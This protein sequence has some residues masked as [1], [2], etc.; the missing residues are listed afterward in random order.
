MATSS[1]GQRQETFSADQA[2]SLCVLS[3]GDQVQHVSTCRKVSL[4][5]G[6]VMTV[7]SVL[8]YG[9]ERQPTRL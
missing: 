7:P 4:G 9:V 6:T 8:V 1:S 3:S 5:P 2:E